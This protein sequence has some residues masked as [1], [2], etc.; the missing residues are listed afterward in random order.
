MFATASMPSPPSTLLHFHR[1]ALLLILISAPATRSASPPGPGPFTQ[2]LLPQPVPGAARA[3]T[4]DGWR[5][6]KLCDLSTAAYGPPRNGSNATA[7]LQQAID[8]CGVRPEGGT[9]LVPGS[10]GTLRTASLWL[11]SNLTLRV[12]DGATLLGTATG[13][14]SHDDEVG[15]K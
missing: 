4:A 5:R 8:D 6:G 2:A 12:E 1:V 14:G 13:S 7:A 11:R 10:V 9:V 3:H 15:G